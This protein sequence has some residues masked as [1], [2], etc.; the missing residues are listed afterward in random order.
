[1]VR[2]GGLVRETITVRIARV[3][4]VRGTPYATEVTATYN[5]PSRTNLTRC[6]GRLGRDA[7]T[8]RGRLTSSLPRK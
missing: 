8:Y 6:P 3:R 7:A 1:V 4:T 2:R 5:N